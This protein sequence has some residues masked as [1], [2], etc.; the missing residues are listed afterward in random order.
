MCPAEAERGGGGGRIGEDDENQ[1]HPRYDG[2]KCLAVLLQV[3][4]VLFVSATSC[5]AI[6]MHLTPLHSE[7]EI[8][9][10]QDVKVIHI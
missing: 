5:A 8:R 7:K 1:R 2:E 3:I 10:R 4:F 9:A 6:K